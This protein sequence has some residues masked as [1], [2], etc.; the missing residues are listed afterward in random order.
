MSKEEKIVGQCK[1]SVSKELE[2]LERMT[3]HLDLD[4]E[5]FYKQEKV[6]EEIIKK[7]ILKAQEQ[8]KVL[9]IIKEKNVDIFRFRKLDF[10]TF[11]QL[12]RSCNLPELTEE[13]FNTLKEYFK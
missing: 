3:E 9:K 6:D 12:Q 10:N 1:S 8:E 5:Y 7:C 4:D 2:A 13:E 11:N